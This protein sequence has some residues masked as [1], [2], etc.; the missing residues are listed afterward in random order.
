[1]RRASAVALFALMAA[2]TARR[3]GY[4]ERDSDCSA[5]QICNLEWPAKFQCVLATLDGGVG[6]SDGSEVGGGD[7]TA[8]CHASPECPAGRP[9]C[10]AGACVACSSA[11]SGSCA[12]R[13]IG[14]P[15]CDP[16]GAC[17]ECASSADCTAEPSRPIC[18]AA[19]KACAPCTGDAQCVAKSGADPG[20]C[21]AHQDG[22]CAAL[23][24]TIFVQNVTGCQATVTSGDV[25]AGSAAVPLCSLQQ[26]V[27]ALSGTR[28]LLVVRG[29]VAGSTAAVQG[30]AGAGSQVSIIGQGNAAIAPPGP[31]GVNLAVSGQDVFVRDL[32]V[33]RGFQ[34]GIVGTA[35]AVLRLQRVIVSDNAGGGILLDGAAFDIADTTVTGNG[36]GT[37]MGF[38]A[39]GGML[40][41]SPPNAGPRTLQGVT[42]QDNKS[43]GLACSVPIV[44]TGVYAAGSVG[45]IDITQ[46]CQVTSCP[47]RGA[48]CGAMP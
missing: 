38:T 39:W 20:V 32:A 31:S 10:V 3:P 1:M 6:G 41:N 45:G 18:D 9:I 28:R 17:V 19:T 26:A 29:T 48:G 36:P 35:G 40:V 25:T 5:G 22:R 47:A 34:I 8:E 24:E 13:D 21:M 33:S 37:F 14:R 23:A 2:C 43:V 12:D 7:S 44:G 15:V 30:T 4:C 16:A 11:P 42:I 27:V 46:A